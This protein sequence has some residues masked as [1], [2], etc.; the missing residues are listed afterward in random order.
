MAPSR[1]IV[2]RCISLVRYGA[3]SMSPFTFRISESRLWT[4]VECHTTVA[5]DLCTK[6]SRVDYIFIQAAPCLNPDQQRTDHSI[7]SDSATVAGPYSA[8]M[9]RYSVH[10][11]LLWTI[12]SHVPLGTAHCCVREAMVVLY[13]YISRCWRS[14]YGASMVEDCDSDVFSNVLMVVSTFA[15]PASSFFVTKPRQCIFLQQSILP[16]LLL[17]AFET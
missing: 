12:S 15:S 9:P 6:S 14:Y 4:V 16:L 1:T 10:T 8:A 7:A 17:L 11:P 13:P 5:F 3:C 2:S